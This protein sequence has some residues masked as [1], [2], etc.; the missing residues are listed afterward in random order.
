MR[1]LLEKDFRLMT[2]RKQTLL[3]FAAIAIVM[4]ISTDGSFIVGYL[5][6]LCSLLSISSIA[7]DEADNGYAFLMTLP[8]TPKLYVREKYFFCAFTCFCAWIVSVILMFILNFIKKVPSDLTEDILMCLLIFPLFILF[9]DFMIPVQLK[10]GVERGRIIF[11]CFGGIICAAIFIFSKIIPEPKAVSNLFSA[12]GTHSFIAV[13]LMITFAA[14]VVFT[15]L[16][17]RISTKIMTDKE[18]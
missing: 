18:Y 4:G 6:F 13:L 17:L 3:L 8:I 5:T 1:G 14:A 2:G 12:L 9:I 7:Y 11:A 15:W 10:F 16:S